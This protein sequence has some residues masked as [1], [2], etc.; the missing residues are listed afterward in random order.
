MEQKEPV[1]KL[2]ASKRSSASRPGAERRHLYF[3]MSMATVPATIASA[4][5]LSVP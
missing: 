1:W 5:S 3:A 4:I 2:V